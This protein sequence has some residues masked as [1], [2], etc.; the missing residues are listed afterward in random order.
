MTLFEKWQV[1]GIILTAI[2]LILTAIWKIIR[3]F[4]SS[5]DDRITAAIKTATDAFTALFQRHVETEEVRLQQ[6]EE[7]TRETRDDVKDMR[8]R[9]I[10]METKIE[11]ME[12]ERRLRHEAEIALAM[13]PTPGTFPAVKR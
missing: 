13:T 9:L 3:A 8:D 1:A 5:I 2:G 10:S 6:I 4:N 7:A 12:I 11:A